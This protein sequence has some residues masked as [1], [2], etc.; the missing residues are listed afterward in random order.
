MPSDPSASEEKDRDDRALEDGLERVRLMI[1]AEEDAGAIRRAWD[2][3]KRDD[4]ADE[5]LQ[6]KMEEL[7]RTVDSLATTTPAEGEPPSI[8][9]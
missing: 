8:E 2:G 4:I 6:Q 3:L 1:L 5:G 7:R 9:A